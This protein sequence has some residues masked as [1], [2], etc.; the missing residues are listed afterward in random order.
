MSVPI[1][2]I[3]APGVDTG[4]TAE[5]IALFLK[6][7]SGEVAV[8]FENTARVRPLIQVRT[9]SSGKSA[10]FAG[11]GNVTAHYHQRGIN[12]LTAALPTGS[13]SGVLFGEKTVGV[14]RVLMAP[15]FITSIDEAMNHYDIRGPLARKSGEALSKHTDQILTRLLVKAAQQTASPLTTDHG[16]GQQL[17]DTT[18]F[19]V[20]NTIGIG[21]REIARRMDENEVPDD[22]R[23]VA[24]TPQT[25]NKVVD[26]GRFIDR[27]FNPDANGSR[28]QGVTLS[29]FGLRLVKTTNLQRGTDVSGTTNQQ[30]T[31]ET[32]QNNYEVDLTN[33]V[34]AAGHTT[35]LGS[36]S[37]MGLAV[38]MEYL[39]EYQGTLMLSKMAVGHDFLRTETAF[40]LVDVEAGEPNLTVLPAS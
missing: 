27:D 34:A 33:T 6:V 31:T 15:T 11:I 29:A 37:L 35:S 36:V 13:L 22:G 30:T 3:S 26:D 4:A 40:A 25:Y 17:G 24:M 2:G 9:I 8:A 20:V 10:Q 1:A 39:I 7:F 38:E 14:D 18:M 28:S 12:M 5:R 16:I 19:T 32:N 21:L 23:F